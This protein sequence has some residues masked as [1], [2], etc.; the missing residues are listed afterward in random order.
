M[1]TYAGLT[2]APVIDIGGM[3]TGK[4]DP[5][6]TLAKQHGISLEKLKEFL[7][8]GKEAS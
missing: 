4:T 6:E 3:I 5:L 7:A 2:A 1:D 8:N